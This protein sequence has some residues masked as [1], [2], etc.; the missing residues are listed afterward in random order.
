MQVG[1]LVLDLEVGGGDRDGI[2]L[3][4]VG[5]DELDVEQAD[6]AVGEARHRQLDGGVAARP[7]IGAA[8]PIVGALHQGR[9]LAVAALDDALGVRLL[10][11][12]AVA[13]VNRDAVR[14][15]PRVIPVI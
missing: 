7:A 8:R 10:L 14:M 3:A 2:A 4:D 5:D 15:P 11:A 6:A 13:L 12:A 9:R 1:R